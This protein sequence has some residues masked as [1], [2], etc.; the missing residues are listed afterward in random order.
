MS[1]RYPCQFTGGGTQA[2]VPEKN[3]REGPQGSVWDQRSR[4]RPLVCPHGS[5]WP[6][7]HQMLISEPFGVFVFPH[8]HDDIF[9]LHQEPSKS[10]QLDQLGQKLM[11]KIGSSWSKRFRKHYGPIGKVCSLSCSYL[12][13]EPVRSLLPNYGPFPIDLVLAV[14]QRGFHAGVQWHTSGIEGKPSEPGDWHSWSNR[15][16]GSL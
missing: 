12:A 7:A 9:G 6:G 3:P 14:P 4:R 5:H 1:N 15:A 13:C 2:K 8:L 11:D 16:H 10:I